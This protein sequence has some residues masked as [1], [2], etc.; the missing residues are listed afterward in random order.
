MRCRRVDK[1][2]N[3][4]Y[5]NSILMRIFFFSICTGSARAFRFSGCIFMVNGILLRLDKIGQQQAKRK[6][7]F[8]WLNFF[9]ILHHI[10]VNAI[11]RLE[12]ADE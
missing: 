11:V 10:S 3:G 8:Q 7:Q 9:F 12:M 4:H 2:Q 5:I 1:T 6:R